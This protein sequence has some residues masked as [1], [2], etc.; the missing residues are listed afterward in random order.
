MAK[1][2]TKSNITK[3]TPTVPK[4]TQ[5]SPV[6]WTHQLAFWGL[7]ILLF[8]PPYFRGLFFQP[9]QE[10]ALI[11]AG[12]VFWLAWLWKWSKRDNN[13][14]SH[15]LD[16][17]ALALPVVYLVSA[18]QAVAYGVAVNEIVKTTLYFITFWLVSRLV[19]NAK[20]VT[21][22]LHVVYFSAIGV[23]LAGLATATGII[24]IKDGFLDGRIYSTLQYPNALAS[25]L[26]AVL[27]IGLYLWRKPGLEIPAASGNKMGAA[28]SKGN[29][30]QYLYATG[31]FLLFTVLL[32][33]R[34]NGGLLVFGI[35]L[36]I[37]IIGLPRGSRI[38]V[39]IH[40]TLFSPPSLLATIMFLNAATGGHQGIAWLWI[41]VGLALAW[42]G[43]ALYHL[44]ERK[45]LLTW[46]AAHKTVLLA[47]LL[48]V[49]TAGCI[50]SG[51]YINTHSDTAKNIIEDLRLRNASERFYF[52]QDA[53]KMFKER[54]IL[55]WG[56]GGW[57]AAYRSY[58]SYLYNSNQVHGYYFQVMVET[59]VLGI[60]VVLGIW[61]SFLY[62]THRLYHGAK[63]NA[64]RQAL[65]LTITSAA[66]MLGLHAVIDFDL[67]LSAI[68]LVLWMMFGLTVSPALSGK[69]QDARKG[70]KYV[71]AN[72]TVLAGASVAALV[73]MV[74]AGCLAWSNYKAAEAGK[75]LQKQDGNKAVAYMEEAIAYNPVNYLYYS[76]LSRI[77]QQ[78]GKTDEA[79][80]QLEQAIN[81][82]RYNPALY[83]DLAN[84]YFNSK[85]YDEAVLNA[86]RSL[87]LAPFQIQWYEVLSRIYFLGGYM[88]LI[89][90][91]KD[92]A[93]DN[94]VKAIGV[95]ELIKSR[96]NSLSDQEKRLWKDAPMLSATPAVSLN[97]G[98]SLYLLGMWPEAE[99]YL[100]TAMQDENNKGEAAVWLSL[101]KDKQGKAQEAR[102]LLEQAKELSPQIANSYESL[103]NLEILE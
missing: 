22:I 43:Q 32:G 1:T 37:F 6:E 36:L 84:L 88:E 42:A 30:I 39:I 35:V 50:F 2:V 62:L 20:D 55:G 94:F 60:L 56:G 98:S 44:A 5:E 79:I 41:A 45:G 52:F 85:N 74:F 47:A 68:T 25:Y 51:F 93:K 46:I 49:V 97:A 54:P 95:P 81:L 31:N 66:V 76:N 21:S 4:K 12:V 102:D 53:M 29:W 72:N 77:Y 100:Q 73:I 57:E 96:V 78:Q 14:L 64:P 65:V 61:G 40:F 17:F 16:Y 11:F 26:A 9:E 83:T 89:D 92:L 7:A 19:N 28:W 69:K 75:S 87:T 90:G 13:F 71:P 80:A 8:L 24:S 86:E 18:F 70:K 99:T 10:R 38:P 3:K 103:K 63:S 58:Q 59:G 15:P 101:L 91:K 27:F 82:N 23:A 34:S 67:S 33:T 48:L